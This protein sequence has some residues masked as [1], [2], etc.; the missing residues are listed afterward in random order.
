MA[1]A[2]TTI[3]KQ[4]TK[5]VQTSD[6]E[7]QK[8]GQQSGFQPITPGG[9]KSI[10]ANPDQAKM[11]NTPAR[12]QAIQDTSA[13]PGQSLQQA[14][15][16]TPAAPAAPEIEPAK[17]KLDRMAGL[18]SINMQMENLVRQKVSQAQAAQPALQVDETKTGAATEA[19]QPGLQAALQQYQGAVTEQQKEAAILAASNALGRLVT[20]DEMSGYFKSSAESVGSA[21]TPQ[22]VRVADLNLQNTAQLAQDLGVPEADLLQYSPEQLKQAIQN[23]ESNEFNKVQA[24]QAEL[25]SATGNRKLQVQQELQALGQTG[26]ATTEAN[27]D[28]LQAAVD[29]GDVVSFNGQK[30]NVADLLGDDGI[31]DMVVT[32]LQNPAALKELQKNEPELAQW[33]S[34]HK[35]ALDALAQDARTAA[36]SVAA[37]QTDFGK[38]KSA[39]SPALFEN[40]FGVSP[41]YLSK[42]QLSDLTARASASPLWNALSGDADLK[43]RLERNPSLAQPLKSATAE[44]IK[45]RTDATKLME[46][47]PSLQ[48]LI[49]FKPGGVATAEEAAKASQWADTFDKLAPSISADN[50]F[51]AAINSGKID[52]ADAEKLVA[53]PRIWDKVKA[54]RQYALDLEQAGTDPEKLLSIF[55]G[56]DTS[57]E[58]FNKGLSKLEAYASMGDP[59]AQAKWAYIKKNIVGENGRLGPEDVDLMRQL[60]APASAGMKAIISDP[61]HTFSDIVKQSKNMLQGGASY[62][63][64][65]PAKEEV[66]AGL[67]NDGLI[68]AKEAESLYQRYGNTGQFEEL[69]NSPWFADKLENAPIWKAKIADNK[70]MENYNKFTAENGPLGDPVRTLSA[71][72]FIVGFRLNPETGAVSY[73]FDKTRYNET[74]QRRAEMDAAIDSAINAAQAELTKYGPSQHLGEGASAQ[75]KLENMIKGLKEMKAKVTQGITGAKTVVELKP[76]EKSTPQEREASNNA[77]V[78]KTTTTSNKPKGNN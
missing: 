17:Q 28:S 32:A 52:V 71:I 26:V 16:I 59:D 25:A 21:F 77:V 61:A 34:T 48:K 12:K 38:L 72:P 8:L 55:M 46:G 4:G 64:S 42:E 67:A 41:Q 43:A 19:Q 3:Q 51:Q 30:M 54:D 76:Q 60:G 53:D 73:S 24:L 2:G 9:A 29:A 37:T 66:A 44:E 62:G 13:A 50:D 47:N 18:G 65:D 7:L 49:G 14:Q 69:L 15:R 35:A 10:G 68:D 33:I 56:V 27:F 58:D 70:V 20:P 5:L 74:P 22:Q 75:S 45:A 6:E 11:A 63:T 39:T 36:S 31:S 57:M 78:K 1:N 40:L 23:V